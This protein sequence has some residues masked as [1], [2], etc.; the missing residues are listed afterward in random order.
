MNDQSKSI[1]DYLATLRRRKKQIV[2]IAAAIMVV[3][4][5]VA[6]LLPPSYRSTA[7]ILIEEQEIPPELIRSTVTSFADQ[8]IQVISQRV[9][10]RANLMQIIE[11]YGLYQGERRRLTNEEVLERMRKDIKLNLVNA[12]V[13]D[14][15]SGQPTRAAIAFTLSYDGQTPDSAQKTAGELTSLYL[16]ENLKTREQSAKETSMFLTEEADSL[17][18]H[19]K[20]TEN[21]LARFKSANFGSL[22]ELAQ[23]NLQLKDRTDSEIMEV[24]R[25]INADQDKK[26]YLAGQ[27]AQIKPNTPMFSASGD[28]I[29]DSEDR[30]KVL[31]SQYASL[32]GIYSA[33]HPDLVKMRREMDS[34]RNSSGPETGAT[35]ERAK[36]LTRLRAEL[37]EI[38]KKYSSEHPDVVKLRR[39]IAALERTSPNPDGAAKAP[40]PENP[41]YIAIKAQLEGV[42][43]E[44]QTLRNKLGE[45]RAK[46]REYETRLQNTPQVEREYLDLTREHENSLKRYQELKAK[47][48]DAQIA[49]QLEKDNKGERFSLIDP[50][51][52]PEKPHSPNRPAI[53]LL[54]LLVALGGGVGYGSLLEALD[55]S[56][57]NARELLLFTSAPLLGVLPY[58]E[59]GRDV[60]RRQYRKLTVLSLLAASIVIALL[61]VH[62]FVAPLDVLWFRLLRRVEG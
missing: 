9:M 57:R 16:R 7:T 25:Q 42:D 41:A 12:D 40:V 43:S 29:L 34:L 62:F 36:E 59:T 5:L 11:K 13:I 38:S 47:Q 18:A 48:M 49:Q 58:V 33:E 35:D 1:G 30:L 14:P 46:S 10:T 60:Q 55:P 27:L 61:L 17:G 2:A 15:R 4:T 50:P 23:L 44:L 22:P 32:S 45:L 39:S 31:Q 24:E 3:V 26:F 51:Q 54:G 20:D 52:L 28:R 6:F 37:A 56:I 19:I 53:L 8:R 21:R